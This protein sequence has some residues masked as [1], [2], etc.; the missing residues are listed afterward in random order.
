MPAPWR[1]ARP[2]CTLPATPPR[3]SPAP[4]GSRATPRAS[5]SRAWRAP[6]SGLRGLSRGLATRLFARLRASGEARRRGGQ[7][8][9]P[10]R[11][12]GKRVGAPTPNPTPPRPRPEAGERGSTAWHCVTPL[13]LYH[14]LCIVSVS[15]RY[16]WARAQSQPQS[17]PSLPAAA[18][19]LSFFPAPSEISQES[20]VS[21]TCKPGIFLP[22]NRGFFL[23]FGLKN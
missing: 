23:H 7:R 4:R 3:P 1:S 15:I 2:A 14:V 5:P 6:P 11:A 19:A 8:G 21:L 18:S 13:Y 22:A 12:L 17:P 10:A 9:R 16:E 20:A